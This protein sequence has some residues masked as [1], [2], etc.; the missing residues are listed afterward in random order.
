MTGASMRYKSSSLVLRDDGQ[1]Q[2]RQLTTQEPGKLRLHHV[3]IYLQC[4]SIY[5]LS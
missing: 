3:R 5:L 2:R 4:S 1:L